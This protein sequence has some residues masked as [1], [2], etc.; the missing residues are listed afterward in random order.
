MN[1]K[2]TGSLFRT[3]D[4]INYLV[5]F[6][7][8]CSL[9]LLW[10]F[11]H[12][13]LDVLDKHFQDTL[14]VSKAQSGFVQFSL[15]IGYLAMAIPA[16]IF[17]KRY[18]YQKGII[19][20]LT[21][22]GI[23]AFLFYP[24]AKFEAFIPFLLALFVIACGLACLET[25]ANPY[26]T[27]LGSQ[28]EEFAARRINISQSFNGLGWILGPLMGGLFIFGAEQQDGAEKFD[29][30][31]KPYMGIGCV[32]VVVAVIFMLIKL[33]DIEEKSEEESE[34]NPKMGRL[35]KHPAFIAAVIAQFLYV[36]AQT[37]VNSFFINYVTEEIPNVTGPVANMMQHLGYFGEVFMPKNAEQAAS[38]ILAIGGMGLFWIGRISGAYLMKFLK[39]KKLLAIYALINTA[40]M[41]FVQLALGWGSVIALFSCY[42]FMSVMF[43][44]I[45]ALGIHGLGSLTKKASSFLV[46][47]VA[48]GAFC[49][50]IMGVVAD[51]SSM[52]VAFFI[53]MLCFAFIAWYAIWGVGKIEHD[54]E[55]ILHHH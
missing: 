39:P 18:G 43:P 37:G 48:G 26:S 51:H 2:T 1:K 9:F 17:M 25:A 20:G 35:L 47:A 36:A 5:P 19:L 8:I 42:F 22:F 4:G 24:A 3:K 44:T 27:V 30:L 21:L 13:L 23:G 49:P 7:F 31:V 28:E 40:L 53:P 15:Y 52:S 41:V 6:M 32:V 29:S 54:N 38:V 45:F 34:E 46:M 14:Q 12:G 16:G 50:P 33:P 10:G 55:I 11:A